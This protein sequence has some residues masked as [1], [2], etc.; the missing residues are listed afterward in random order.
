MKKTIIIL[1]FLITVILFR[2]QSILLDMEGRG[3]TLKSIIRSLIEFCCYAVPYLIL[4]YR[5][6]K[7]KEYSVIISLIIGSLFYCLFII[8]QALYVDWENRENFFRIY[9]E[10]LFKIE[11]FFRLLF[12]TIFLFI[13]WLL[14]KILIKDSNIK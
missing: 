3:L 14:E 6:G 13:K 4:S 7:F 12:I 5:S 11:I 2:I 10:I 9:I 1:A 8:A